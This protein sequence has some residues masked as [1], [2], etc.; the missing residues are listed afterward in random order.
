M[1][2]AT[3][4][5]KFASIV[6]DNARGFLPAM[7]QG[8]EAKRRCRRRIGSVDDAKYAALFAQ[9]VA[10]LIEERVSDIHRA[11]CRL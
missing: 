11:V 5:E 8:M 4:D 3:P 7:L 10:I 6:T 9:L 1:T 2:E